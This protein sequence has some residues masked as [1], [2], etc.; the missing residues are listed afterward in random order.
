MKFH[1]VIYVR[2]FPLTEAI[3]KDLYFDELKKNG[4]EVIYLDLTDLF[5]K[6]SVTS[7]VFEFEGTR[8]INSY[9]QLKKYL[10]EEDNS[11]TL[12][13]SI[14]TFEWRVYR[15]F[16]LFTKFNLVLGVFA[17]GVFPSNEN[18]ANKFNISNIFKKIN[19]E[20]IKAFCGNKIIYTAKKYGFIKSYDYIFKAGEFGYYG[21]GL[22]C[23]IDLK[24]GK[25]VEVNTVDYDQFL[26]H[27]DSPTIYSDEYIV[28]LDQYLPYHPDSNY[29]NIKTVKPEPYFK[30]INSFFNKLESLTGKKVI[31]AAHPKAKNYMEFNPYENRQIF[32]NQSNNLVKGAF[33]VLT[34]ASTAICF[35]VCY[36]KKIVLLLSNY[37]NDRLPHFNS[38]AQSIVW[39]CDATIFNMD[40]EELID[41]SKQVDLQKY[42]DFK[43]KYLTSNK[44]KNLMS[45]D[46]FINFIKNNNNNN[47]LA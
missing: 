36:K 32:F 23:E 45:K 19:F 20:N 31:I 8:K 25:I 1:K 3:Y 33:I 24:K 13:I 15:L 12:F 9:N 38:V 4:I 6:K 17:R 29:F 5:Y 37:L 10:K 40:S 34:H 30:E 41:L 43:F 2:Y 11:N 39:A 27:S 18:S 47:E 7:S 35:P 22:G 14:M 28:F 16:R 21:I 44:T 42:D 26:L 46:I